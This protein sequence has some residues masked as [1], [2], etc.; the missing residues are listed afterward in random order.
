MSLSSSLAA[1][2]DRASRQS[3]QPIQLGLERVADLLQ[4]LDNPH[5][6]LDS[7]HV[8]GTN[9]KGSILAML[10]AILAQAGYRVGLYTSPHLSRVNERICVDGQPIADQELADRLTEVLAISAGRS[11]TFFEL[12]TAVALRH[13]FLQGFGRSGRTRPAIVLLETGL[14]GRL[15]ATN[16]VQPLVSVVSSIALDHTEYLGT[17]LA[18]IAA[19]KAGIFKT[20]IPAV[21]AAAVPEVEQVLR[22]QARRMGTPLAILGQDFTVH[23]APGEATWLFQE[24]TERYRLPM[25]ALLGHHQLENAAL[26]IAAIRRLQAAGWP[27]SQ[28][29]M[30]AGMRQASWPGRLE[31]LPAPPSFGQAPT[32]LLDGAH[33]PAGC[34]ALAHALSTTK[35]QGFDP[36]LLIFSALQDKQVEAMISLLVPHVERVWTVQVGGERGRSSASL[37]A[38]WRDAGRPAQSCFTP[39][40]ALTAA[41]AACPPAGQVVVCGSL[42]L[43][44]SIREILRPIF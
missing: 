5:H 37:A 25:P 13:F 30:E 35:A 10:A 21:A 41:C 18:A 12:L 11:I 39:M 33:N 32:I 38:L 36:T 8:A 17:T 15:D 40:E 31:R 42:Y 22:A 43:V 3:A 24:G 4:A 28:L 16:S 34:Q 6:T 27:V 2:L 44:G 19:E 1:L 9:G 26:A 20:A 29:A 14:G 23:A 7:V